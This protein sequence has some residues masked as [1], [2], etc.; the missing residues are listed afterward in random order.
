MRFRSNALLRL[1]VAVT[2]FVTPTVLATQTQPPIRSDRPLQ[3]GIEIISITA[4]VTDKE[5]RLITGL[6]REAF[7]VFEDGVSQTITQF[8]NERVPVGLGVALDISDSMFGK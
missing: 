6:G 5:G 7:A 8:T 3:S 1:A 2:I 4:T